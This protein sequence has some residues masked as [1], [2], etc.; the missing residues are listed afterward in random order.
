MGQ[1]EIYD[2]VLKHY[3]VWFS[4]EELSEHFG[5]NKVNVNRCLLQLMKTKSVER[6]QTKFF[7]DGSSWNYYEY[8]VVRKNE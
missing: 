3:Y 2:W 7:K 8:R 1:Y 4:A 6:K 5:V